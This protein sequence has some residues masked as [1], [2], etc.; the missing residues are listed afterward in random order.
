MPAANIVT[1]DL[2]AGDY[3]KGEGRNCFSAGLGQ[4]PI[5]ALIG[6]VWERYGL[7]AVCACIV[8]C[9][10]VCP[11]GYLDLL[12]QL[13]TVGEYGEDVFR[14]EAGAAQQLGAA[15]GRPAPSRRAPHRPT[16]PP[17]CLCSTP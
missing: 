16:E 12:S 17:L 8:A 14:G 15:R 2:E 4:H 5:V 7:V 1:R 9:L 11:V 10:A 13:T 3:H 6:L